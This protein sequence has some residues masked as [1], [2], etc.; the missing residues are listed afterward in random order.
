MPA[1]E[2]EVFVGACRE[3]IAQGTEFGLMIQD[4][5]LIDAAGEQFEHVH[6]RRYEA[7]R[8]EYAAFVG[9]IVSDLH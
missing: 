4:A 8:D 9:R 5:M 2:L 7:F 3:N 6:G 1:E